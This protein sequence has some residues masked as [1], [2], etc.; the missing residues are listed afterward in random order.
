MK[1]KVL[2]IELGI[3]NIKFFKKYIKHDDMNFLYASSFLEVI[4]IL[5]L[6]KVHII[7]FSD[8]R[9]IKSTIGYIKMFKTTNQ[10][11]Y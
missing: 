3:K 10:I 11:T 9:G 2:I 8:F 6:D 7:V 4:D 5:H 1:L